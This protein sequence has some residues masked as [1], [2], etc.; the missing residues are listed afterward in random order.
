MTWGTLPPQDEFE[1]AFD[2]KVNGLKYKIKAGAASQPEWFP[3]GEYTSDELYELIGKM[4][5]IPDE[6]Q[7]NFASDILG[8]LGFE[9]I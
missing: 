8:T 1:Q 4:S 2:G 6:E 3:E 7:Q 5:K 9:W